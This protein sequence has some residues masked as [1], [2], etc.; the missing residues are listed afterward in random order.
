METYNDKRIKE[1]EAELNDKQRM[2]DRLNIEAVDRIN[3]I[4]DLK[5]KLKEKEDT[6][7]YINEGVEDLRHVIVDLNAKLEDKDEEIERLTEWKNDLR[8]SCDELILKLCDKEKEI[9]CLKDRAFDPD[10]EAYRNENKIL[11]DE[12][13]KK[14]EA[15]ER[16]CKVVS[17][18][19]TEISNFKRKVREL[20]K[21]SL[22]VFVEKCALKNQIRDLE[23]KVTKYKNANDH[24]C[25][26]NDQLGEQLEEKDEEIARLEYRI[27]DLETMV[28]H[29]DQTIE[30]LRYNLTFSPFTTKTIQRP[31]DYS[32]KT[33]I[34]KFHKTLAAMPNIEWSIDY[35]PEDK[36]Y[37]ITIKH[38]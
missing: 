5:A 29:R 20:E 19:A 35:D 28:Q 34:V 38:E 18:R 14:T 2:I 22:N 15:Y 32:I 10:L 26:L 36:E 27:V 9:A 16:L 7:T 33:E 1:L 25:D 23:E 3:S 31:Y 6:I 4:D 13:D 21:T 24:T 11:K 30:R 37:F 12:L 8:I 17:D